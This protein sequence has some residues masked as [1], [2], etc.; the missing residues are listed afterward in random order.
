MLVSKDYWF[1]LVLATAIGFSSYPNLFAQSTFSFRLEAQSPA[2]EGQ[3]TKLNIWLKNISPDPLLVVSFVFSCDGDPGA[4]RQILSYQGVD[5]DGEELAGETLAMSFRWKYLRAEGFR[6]TTKLASLLGG[7]NRTSFLWL[8][9]VAV[10]LPGKGLK[11][12]YMWIPYSLTGHRKISASLSVRYVK[13]SDGLKDGV[14]LLREPSQIPQPPES[15]FSNLCGLSELPM[16]CFFKRSP[17]LWD[18]DLDFTNALVSFG[19]IEGQVEEVLETALLIAQQEPSLEKVSRELA[20]PVTKAA[21]SQAL[22]TWFLK[23]GDGFHI[24]GENQRLT[25]ES[26][27]SDFI[28]TRLLNGKDEK[29]W[30]IYN[31]RFTL[32]QEIAEELASYPLVEVEG[33]HGKYFQVPLRK[34]IDV[35]LRVDRLGFEVNSIGS[36]SRKVKHPR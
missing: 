22:K 27:F 1:I 19:V 8:P 25:L 16:T 31:G 2:M 14:Y 11:S 6:P 13:W 4:K 28:E 7:G 18:S 24:I 32:P 12:G 29:P 35:L 36:I 10:L 15:L 5:A 33:C 30:L 26:D 3:T 20:S 9:K 34:I 17:Y 23:N 21:Y